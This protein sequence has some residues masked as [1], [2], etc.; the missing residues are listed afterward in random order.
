[1]S[2]SR[3]FEDFEEEW[4]RLGKRFSVNSH[5]GSRKRKLEEAEDSIEVEVKRRKLIHEDPEVDKD[6]VLMTLRY[7]SG[8]FVSSVMLMHKLWIL[9][10]KFYNSSLSFI[11]ILVSFLYR[12][13]N[14]EKME[15]LA[16]RMVTV[17]PRR[18]TSKLPELVSDP[19]E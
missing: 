15:K 9:N 11:I 4:L 1:M 17:S 3:R 2:S 6:R 12:E 13:P 14:P 18:G 7:L 19:F 5:S 10:V 8:S 16:K